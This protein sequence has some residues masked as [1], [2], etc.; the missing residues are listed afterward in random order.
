[1]EAYREWIKN[2]LIENNA[3]RVELPHKVSCQQFSPHNQCNAHNP[4]LF[5]L[6]EKNVFSQQVRNY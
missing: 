4:L 6:P 1:M 3:I 2:V 5:N